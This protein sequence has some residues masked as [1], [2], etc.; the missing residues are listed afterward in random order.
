VGNGVV[1]EED[2][3]LKGWDVGT[4]AKFDEA[5][6]EVI[7]ADM[8]ETTP[9]N[10][11]FRDDMF[12]Y[13]SKKRTY[14]DSDSSEPNVAVN[15]AR[16]KK[17]KKR[18]PIPSRKRARRGSSAVATDSDDD[19]D[20]NQRGLGSVSVKRRAAVEVADTMPR[21]KMKRPPEQE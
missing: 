5:R 3:R 6:N 10:G 11:T 17:G 21:K 16:V 18:K 2:A 14:S 1:S 13:R 7:S 4:S 20:G 9:K 19:H 15:N 8:V 12:N